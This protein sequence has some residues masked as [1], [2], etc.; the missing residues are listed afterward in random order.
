MDK[1]FSN[2]NIKIVSRL[3]QEYQQL[4]QLRYDVL[5]APL[6]LDFSVDFL[7]KDAADILIGA[8][9]E[10]EAIGC[11]QLTPISDSVFQLRQMAVSG[12]LQGGGVGTRLVQFAEEVAK[13]NGGTKITLHAREVATGFYQKL[14]YTA[15]GQPFTEI[16]LPHIEMVKAL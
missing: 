11:C 12:K 2:L 6:G 7:A 4:V 1:S 5:R 16:G 13:Q 8:F 3:S 14:H 10:D 15:I 9:I